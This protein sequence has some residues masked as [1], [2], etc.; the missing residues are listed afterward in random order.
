MD[1]T[2]AAGAAD[3]EGDECVLSRGGGHFCLSSANLHTQYLGSQIPKEKGGVGVW[4]DTLV[5][6]T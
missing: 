6:A 4:S 2:W 1:P 3:W 5:G